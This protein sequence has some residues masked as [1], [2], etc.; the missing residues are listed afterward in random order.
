MYN[1]LFLINGHG[2]WQVRK[3]IWCL[4]MFFCGISPCYFN[5]FCLALF[6]LVVAFNKK[7]LITFFILVTC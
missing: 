7:R 3:F 1:S 4:H 6:L 2:N 5:G